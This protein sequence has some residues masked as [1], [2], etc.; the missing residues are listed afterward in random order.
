MLRKWL[1]GKNNDEE[2][3]QLK[4]WAKDDPFLADALDG[5]ESFPEAN[6]SADLK[7]MRS[8]IKNKYASNNRGSI[9]QL[10]RIA[11]AASIMLVLGTA[12]WFGL[13]SKSDLSN[14]AMEKTAAPTTKSES[15][16]IVKQDKAV[17]S[18]PADIPEEAE[19]LIETKKENA[20]AEMAKPKPAL[21]RKY[22]N[23]DITKVNKDESENHELGFSEEEEMLADEFDEELNVEE[24]EF[25][26]TAGTVIAANEASPVT[27]A[28][29]P[30]RLEQIPTD[31]KEVDSSA[32]E[33][34]MVDRMAEMAK[35]RPIVGKVYSNAG[36]PLIGARIMASGSNNITT[37]DME[38]VFRL[39]VKENIRDIEIS[40]LGFQPMTIPI[41][42]TDSIFVVLDDAADIAM[43][44]VVVMSA[45]K[46]KKKRSNSRAKSEAKQDVTYSLDKSKA[47]PEGGY[48]K[49]NRY[50]RKNIKL[51]TT[52]ISNNTSAQVILQ[53]SIESDGR[54]KDIRVLQS[55]NRTCDQEAIRLLKAGPVWKNK[56]NFP[57]IITTVSIKCK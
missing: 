15:K 50:I 4:E 28:S 14:I 16:P 12:M 17:A 30:T 51:P 29:A 52:A 32:S 57:I 43:D 42:K 49:F 27:A 40:H 25:E 11:A 23:K 2:R 7:R 48:R 47:V 46:A 5:Y 20:A 37:S 54:P 10:S 26:T 56:T 31:V 8:R 39:D 36:E 33:E 41:S 9:F 18:A 13:S 19:D 24:A 1:F 35:P 21:P 44:E 38:G 53:F 3:S 34:A 6:H 45:E 55:L 22:S